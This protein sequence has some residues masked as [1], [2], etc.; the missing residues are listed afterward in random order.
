[1]PVEHVRARRPPRFDLDALASELADADP[2][3]VRRAVDRVG[4]HL[5]RLDEAGF[6][7]AVEML[8]SLF[9]VDIADLPDLEA[10]LDHTVEVLAAR[11]RRVVPHLLR[12]M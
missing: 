11:G 9:Y 12:Q 10:V 1:L 6:R 8:T 3:V 7:R 2:G 5:G 4:A